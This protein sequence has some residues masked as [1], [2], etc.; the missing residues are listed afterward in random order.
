M[1]NRNDFKND[2]ISLSPDD[3]Y[4]KHIVKSSV[5][6]FTEYLGMKSNELV[7]GMDEFKQIVSKNFHI[8]FHNVQIVGSAKTGFSLSPNRLLEPFAFL[9]DDNVSDIDVAII[10]DKLFND[11][12][13]KLRIYKK[14]CYQNVYNY[15][16]K[17]IFRGYISDRNI[18]KIEGVNKEWSSLTD[19]LNV[20]L[21]D[22]LGFEHPISYRIYRNWDD[23]EE[24]QMSG[25]RKARKELEGK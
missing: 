20:S 5:W 17:S 8:N 16:C 3:F 9:D 25:I 6:Y 1:Y 15:I 24:Y 14:I 7:D 2:L 13:D 22:K 23:L 11:Y 12:W 10:S 21:Q 18:L 4:Y 19:S